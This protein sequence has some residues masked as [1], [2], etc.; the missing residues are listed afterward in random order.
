MAMHQIRYFLAVADTLNFTRAAEQCH[1]AQPS[2]SRAICKLELGLGGDG[3][4]MMN[5]QELE[6]AI[7]MGLDLVVLVLDDGSC[8]MIRW[9]QQQAG[10]PDWGLEFGNPDFVAYAKSYGASARRIE[11]AEDF[12]PALA[13]AFEAST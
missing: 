12:G 5:S 8:G 10:F 9:K 4:F 13:E 6:T 11:S 3:G 2:L 7:R 1:V